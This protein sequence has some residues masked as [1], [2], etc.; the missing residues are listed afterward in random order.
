MNKL[1]L[2]IVVVVVLVMLTAALVGDVAI[3]RSSWS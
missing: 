2:L 3:A 1:V